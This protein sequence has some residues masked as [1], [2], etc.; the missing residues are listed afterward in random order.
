MEILF[1]GVFLRAFWVAPQF[2]KPGG[3]TSRDIWEDGRLGWPSGE[4]LCPANLALTLS[5]QPYEGGPAHC[6]G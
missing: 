3:G 2:L 5:A 6:C 1:E 4:K